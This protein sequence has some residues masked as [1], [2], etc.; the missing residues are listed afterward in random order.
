MVVDKEHH[1]KLKIIYLTR[2]QNTSKRDHILKILLFI[3]IQ[4]LKGGKSR[5]DVEKYTRTCEYEWYET[6]FPTIKHLRVWTGAN[7]KID[8]DQLL[9]VEKEG[10]QRTIQ[11]KSPANKTNYK[12][13]GIENFSR[14]PL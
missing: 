3:Q 2:S 10:I 9:I 12:I 7:K 5:G 4:I 6:Y 11:K 8:K 14:K 13:K 1:K